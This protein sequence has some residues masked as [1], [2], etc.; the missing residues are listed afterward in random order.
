MRTA[1]RQA[2]AVAD[3]PV[4]PI[5]MGI[6]VTVAVAIAWVR[7]RRANYAERRSAGDEKKMFHSLTII[8]VSLLNVR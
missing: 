1:P 5:G 2:H 6:A 7:E 3:R 8:A 4:V